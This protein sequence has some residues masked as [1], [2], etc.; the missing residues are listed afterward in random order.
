MN[1]IT[2]WLFHWWYVKKLQEQQSSPFKMKL[3]TDSLKS[4]CILEVENEIGMPWLALKSLAYKLGIKTVFNN[5]IR[6]HRDDFG[7]QSVV[8]NPVFTQNQIAE[9]KSKFWFY[10]TILISF[11]IAESFL[12]SL[13][14]SLFV[15]GGGLLLQI[16]VAI[17]LAIL[18]M[19]GLDYAFDKHFIYR[20][21]IERHSKKELSEIELV[22]YKD[23]RNIGYTIIVLSFTAIIFS[24]LARIYYLE[25]IPSKGLPPERLISVVQASKMASVFTLAVTLIAALYMAMLKRDQA[26]IGIRFRMFKTWHAAHVQRNSYTQDLIKHANKIVLTTESV[27]EK[28][29]QLVIDL[30]RVYKMGTE[31]DERFESLNTEYVL[32]KVQPGFTLTDCL[33]RTFA[34]IQCAYEELF[35]YG[36]M[37]AKEIKD[38]LTFA[39]EILTVPEDHLEEHLAAI[40]KLKTEEVEET[41]IIPATNGKLKNHQFLTQ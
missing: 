12:Y 35:K 10:R 41:F 24:G 39:S 13:T 14:A 4:N 37:N 19:L 28:H 5:R 32:L 33:Y 8:A 6:I 27:I 34:P 36:V 18:V 20:D 31:Y 2:N 9:L 40:P 7:K 16:P 11:C 3:E 26:K 17:F 21:V 29:W 1:K 25:Y 22:K 23:V 30:K 15:P 38:K